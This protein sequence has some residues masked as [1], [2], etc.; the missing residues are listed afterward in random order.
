MSVTRIK[1]CL[2]CKGKN[3][4]SRLELKFILNRVKTYI[5]RRCRV[6]VDVSARKN[7]VLKI[8]WVKE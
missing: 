8:Y 1:K 6:R 7:K 3:I 2:E 4:D 5:C